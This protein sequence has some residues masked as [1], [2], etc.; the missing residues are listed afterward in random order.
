MTKLSH[1]DKKFSFSFNLAHAKL[2]L[3]IK[4]LF[5]KCN[6]IWF[7]GKL[8]N[9]GKQASCP[10]PSTSVPSSPKLDT[11]PQT[12]IRQS[13]FFS[14]E[15]GVF[16]T[17]SFREAEPMGN[18]GW[19]P[20]MRK[21]RWRNRS[22]DGNMKETK[23]RQ[24]SEEQVKVPWEETPKTGRVMERQIQTEYNTAS[25]TIQRWSTVLTASL[26]AYSSSPRYG[27]HPGSPGWPC[28]ALPEGIS[29]C[30]PPILLA[31]PTWVRCCIW[32]P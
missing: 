22:R 6:D 14:R 7:V 5:K 2:K 30:W 18:R 26:L 9:G 25:E 3:L 24:R 28:P 11:A 31:I 4:N 1:S 10:R 12:L 8:R 19:E 27:G 15:G 13:G 23:Q 20:R 32:E 21:K 17:Y 16:S 29:T